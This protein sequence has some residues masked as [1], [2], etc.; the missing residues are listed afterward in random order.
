MVIG[1]CFLFHID[2][3]SSSVAFPHISHTHGIFVYIVRNDAQGHGE[4]F[5]STSLYAVIPTIV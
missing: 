4:P 5:T 2:F 3:A 1:V